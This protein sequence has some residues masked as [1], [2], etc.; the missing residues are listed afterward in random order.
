[1]YVIIPGVVTVATWFELLFVNGMGLPFNTG[2]VIYALLLVAAIIY[3][4]M[5]TVRKKLVLWNT[6][7]FEHCCNSDWL[8]HRLQ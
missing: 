7:L 2:V 4:I 1:M 6:V 8:F 5:Y 3:G